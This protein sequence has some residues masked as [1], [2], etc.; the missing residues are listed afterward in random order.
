[1]CVFDGAVGICFGVA[2]HV[3]FGESNL[4]ASGGSRGV[5][6]AVL[7]ELFAVEV[8]VVG[9]PILARFGEET[10]GPCRSFS[11]P[12]TR[13]QSRNHVS[14][15]LSLHDANLI[16]VQSYE[17]PNRLSSRAA[18]AR[19]SAAATSLALEYTQEAAVVCPRGQRE[20][21]ANQWRG[22]SR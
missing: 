7:V 2:R 11:S 20:A 14:R 5:I 16:F 1:M 18:G 19:R 22:C 9:P 8:K 17:W 13:Y 4:S 21:R 6:V 15:Q 10:T 12:P 3:G